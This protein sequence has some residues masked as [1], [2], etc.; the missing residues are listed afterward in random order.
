[1]AFNPVGQ[2]FRRPNL[3]PTCE[4]LCAL[5]LLNGLMISRIA[6]E[7]Q[8]GR[9]FPRGNGPTQKP[10]GWRLIGFLTEQKIEGIPVLSHSTIQVHPLLLEANIGFVTIPGVAD[11]AMSVPRLL[12]ELRNVALD[13]RMRQCD[14]TFLHSFLTNLG[15]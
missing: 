10:Q 11:R 15:N 1:M 5:Q 8:L 12:C 2:T 4:I 3:H 7:R 13:R 14:P 9:P 6:I